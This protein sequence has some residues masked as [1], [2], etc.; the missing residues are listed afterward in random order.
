MNNKTN[1]SKLIMDTNE[2]HPPGE[3][4]FLFKASRNVYTRILLLAALTRLAEGMDLTY[5]I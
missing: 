2:I 5:R 4:M 3:E 1:I